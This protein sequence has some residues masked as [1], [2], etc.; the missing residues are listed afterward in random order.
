MT[1]A[2]SSSVWWGGTDEFDASKGLFEKLA[3]IS[4]RALRDDASIDRE[5][6]G[7]WL[8]V[9]EARGYDDYQRKAIRDAIAQC[10]LL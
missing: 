2:A 7:E 10:K 8:K 1:P 5:G 3:M 9:L 4:S 6:K